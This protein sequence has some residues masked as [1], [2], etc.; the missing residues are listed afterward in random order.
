MN[1]ATLFDKNYLSRG[2]VMF[3]SLKEVLHDQINLFVLCLDE[4]VYNYFEN[5]KNIIRIKLTD[6]EMYF[7]NLIQAKKNRKFNEYIF[8][9]SPFLP[10]YILK[11]FLNVQ[12]ITTIDAD[13]F[14]L[15]NP[16]Q[17]IDK[18]GD[19][20]IGITQHDFPL[21]LKNLEIYGKFNVSF[22]SF[23]NTQDSLECLAEWSNC[24]L[25]Y[26][27]DEINPITEM[28]ADQKYLDSWILKY[29]FI[30]IFDCPSI[31]LA[32][33]NVSKYNI[34]YTNKIFNIDNTPI[35]FYHFHNFRI[36][37]FFFA[38]H[39]V[40]SYGLNNLNKR[41]KKLY[42]IYWNK[43]TE[44]DFYNSDFQLRS[45][46]ISVKKSII[47]DFKNYPLLFKFHFLI[48]NIDTRSI[49]SF[50]HKIFKKWLT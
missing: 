27:G 39:G 14:F 16:K 21:E 3:N 23:P 18:L 35:I 20:Y 13:L 11:N 10:L 17:V 38:I 48:F 25:E 49:L 12:R 15:N 2:V 36:R 9:L 5:E 37:N 30:K 33:W 47:R 8:T 41:L 50:T 44:Y 26:C 7:P 34:T 31:G 46:T 1:F 42:L 24:C 32:P 45:N 28:F 40:N 19:N 29:N 43:I 6:L 22:Q 4:D